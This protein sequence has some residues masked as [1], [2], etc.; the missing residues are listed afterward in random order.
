MTTTFAAWP[1]PSQGRIDFTASCP[2]GQDAAWKQIGLGSVD[3]YV[4]SC[5]CRSSGTAGQ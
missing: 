5:S 4:I 3:V 2:C 1:Q